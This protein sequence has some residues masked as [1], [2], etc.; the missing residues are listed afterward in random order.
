MTQKP[1]PDRTVVLTFDDG[2]KSD[3]NHVAPLLQA[4]GFGAT[5][6]IT[7]GLTFL[8]NKAHRLTWDEVRALHEMG[9]EIGNHSRAHKRVDAQSKNE[10][11]ADLEHIEARCAEHGIPTPRTF[12]YPGWHHSP[13]AVAVLTEKGYKYARRGV[14]PEFPVELGRGRAYDPKCDHPLLVPTTGSSGPDWTFA[15]F[16]AAVEQARDGKISVLTFH[17]VPDL[18]HPW[19]DTE[20][21]FFD[22]CMQYL[23]DN[24]YTVIAL[25]DL[26]PDFFDECMQYLH[27]NDYTVIALGDLA[28]YVDPAIYA[29]DPYASIARQFELTPTDLRTEYATNP[30]GIASQ[31]PRFS[32][33]LQSRQR[34]EKQSA[35]QVLVASSEAQLRADAG[36]KW[37]SGKVA[38]D[39]SAH[40]VYDGRPLTSG[41]RCHWKVRVWDVED[42][43]TPYSAPATFEMGLLE[44]SDWG[45]KWITA[46]E[47]SSAPLL[48]R[49]F[50]IEKKV[51]R[52]R[53]YVSGLGYYE[54]YLS[55]KKVGD[56]VLDPGTTYYDNVHAL[57]IGSR[58]LYATYDVSDQLSMGQNAIGVMLGHGWYSS[59]DGHPPGRIPY[60]ERPILILQVNVEFVD[61]EEMSIVSDGTWKTSRGPI[62]ANDMAKGETYDARQEQPGWDMPCFDDAGWQN[63][64]AAQPPSGHL[65]A[66]M[67]EPIKVMSK[68]RPVRM[69]QLRDDAYIFD[70]GQFI[71]GWVELRVQGSRGTV[72]TLRHAGRV[73]PDIG[74][75][76]TRNN[77]S[78]APA[79]QTDVYILK[80]EGLEV[81]QPRFTLHGFRYVEVSGYPGEPTLDAVCGQVVHSSVETIGR[82]ACSN[83]LL[84]R[85][86]SNTYWTF[87]GS[88]QGIPQD[89]AD[90]AERVGWLGDP[91]FVAE[92]YIKNFYCVRFWA[93]WM[94]DIKDAQKPD[95]EVPYVC[96]IHWGEKSYREWPTWQSAYPMF[97][98]YLYQYYGDERVLAEHCESIKRLVDYFCA[99]AKDGIMTKGLG[100]HMEP[101]SDGT[102]SFSPT[103]TPEPLCATAY[104]SYSAWIV[105]QV[106]RILGH[107]EDE[108]MY[109]DLAVKIGDAFN[110]QFLNP[111]TNQYA[112]GSQTS[113]ALP[114]SLDLVPGG[115]ERAVLK[116][117]VDDIVQ[118]HDGHLSTGIVGTNALE[119]A[120]PRYGRADV[121]YGIATQTTF[122]SW[123]YG[124]VHG[125]TTIW[126]DLEGSHRRSVSM[127]MFGSTQKFFYCDL[128]GI[129]LASPGYKTIV[130][131]PQVVGD[132]TYV[133]ASLRTVSGLIAVDWHRGDKTLALNV[134]IPVNTNALIHVP[135]LGLKKVT[136]A[137]NGRTCWASNKYVAGVPGVTGGSE[138]DASI[139]F[140][141]GAGT[142]AFWLNEG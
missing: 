98:W 12:C 117:L 53:A 51:A 39:Q 75:L 89:A 63:A 56:H 29:Q 34:G 27:D 111:E 87:K 2:N 137:E 129:G 66:Q 33:L 8:K 107:A 99:R 127:K 115:R 54:L 133:R 84:N 64:V 55:G 50:S 25:G 10:F 58:V 21:D 109:A 128:A 41:E 11:R 31:R 112:T 5:F 17:G 26:A 37:D 108:A 14:A 32:W 119:Q 132:L 86:H 122:P 88:F 4:Y 114:L 91:A 120:L 59:D 113:N 22:E 101:R 100:D 130:V 93:K 35:Y 71:S 138:D 43:P 78:F 79:D 44:D 30:L 1:V 103:R 80:G 81:W 94:D 7:E 106:S 116:N 118:T 90:R 57:D 9:F 92:D 6:F 20:P 24:D 136:V 77:E 61:G 104:Y 68:I 49:E 139:T 121:M 97:V 48:R 95:G 70:L 15:D 23:Y 69:F 131:K 60:A 40:V 45:S 140:A 19:V 74:S 102:S 85:I 18:D 16:L 126:E 73:N 3:I 105:S 134:T 67:M 65:T 72:V 42:K 142:Y 52:A 141:V 135:K 82:F 47:D 46:P 76:D 38:S 36:D 110:A 13:E 62:L 123:G 83:R 125:A 96:P 28:Q 124:V